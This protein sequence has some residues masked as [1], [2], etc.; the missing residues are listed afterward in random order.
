MKCGKPLVSEVAITCHECITY[1]PAFRYATGYGVYNGVLKKAIGFLKYHGVRR[2]AIPLSDCMLQLDMPQFDAVIPV[3][4]H[5]KRLREREFNQSALFSR[6]IS[7]RQGALLLLDCL[8]KTR[9]TAPQVGL[10][11]K[12]RMRNVRKAFSVINTEKLE[13]RKILLVDDVFTTGATVRECSRVL[14]DAGVR[15]VYVITLAHGF[16]D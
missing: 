7:R 5:D 2:L 13:G 10:H 15:D 6:Y 16:R 12:D 3:P 14:M 1:E 9:E 11:L 4:L 8:V